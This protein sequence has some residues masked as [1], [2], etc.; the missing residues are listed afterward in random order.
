S[1]QEDLNS[2]SP[3]LLIYPSLPLPVPSS[4]LAIIPVPRP[5]VAQQ[6]CET[7]SRVEKGS[8]QESHHAAADFVFK[9]PDQITIEHVFSDQP[10][11]ADDRSD[12]EV[13]VGHRVSG[14]AVRVLADVAQ[15]GLAEQ[16]EFKLR[17]VS[18]APAE[19]LQTA[20]PV[21]LIQ[22]DFLLGAS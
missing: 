2:F 14:F 18:D 10:S 15:G 9:S 19:G 5:L 8:D 3:C 7:A 22:A 4:S 20:L 13:D 12:D 16:P 11:R 21:T 1:I 6:I 17:A